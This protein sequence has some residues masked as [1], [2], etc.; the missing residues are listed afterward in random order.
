MAKTLGKI[1]TL[2][3]AFSYSSFLAGCSGSEGAGTPSTSDSKPESVGSVGLALQ[4]ASG[5]SLDSAS[6]TITGP[7]GFTKTGSI[8][9]SQATKLSATI[10]GLP[11]GTGFTITLTGTTS[12][13]G[14]NCSGSASFSIAARKTTSVAVS[15]ACHETGRTGSVM[16]S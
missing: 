12:D 3:L 6:Y 5:T 13:A 10:G 16:V 14:G 9:V 15:M 1:A 2:A 7:N 4:L 8:D 11:V